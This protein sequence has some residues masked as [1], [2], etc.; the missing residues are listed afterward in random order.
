MA[1]H[2]RAFDALGDPTR[3]SIFERVASRPQSVGKLAGRMSVSR[4]AVSQHLRV[5]KNAG[6]AEG[7]VTQADLVQCPQPPGDPLGVTSVQLL[8]A[9]TLTVP[10]TPVFEK[11]I[12]TRNC[13]LP[14]VRT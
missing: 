14:L 2:A 8:P 4:P 12:S 6:L 1:N 9:G 5:L 11:L 3:R 7:D 10:L 13:V